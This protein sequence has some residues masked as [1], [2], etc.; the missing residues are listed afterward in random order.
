MGD[1]QN[2][3]PSKQRRM[4]NAEMLLVK[5]LQKSANRDQTREL[6]ET[7]DS[8]VPILSPIR[9]H[10]SCLV[11][12]RSVTQ[13]L[14]DLLEHV[15]RIV[16]DQKKGA[17]GISST[18]NMLYKRAF[19]DSPF[20]FLVVSK[21]NFNII[22]MSNVLEKFYVSIPFSGPVGH[23]ILHF[24]HQSEQFLLREVL[25]A[26]SD[27]KRLF[28]TM[29]HF[30]TFDDKCVH[31][32]PLLLRNVWFDDSN[33]FAFLRFVNCEDVAQVKPTCARPEH[34]N[35]D[36][37]FD[38]VSSSILPA[39]LEERIR[40]HEPTHTEG[41]LPF[42]DWHKSW[43][44]FERDE[45]V[46]LMA[47]QLSCSERSLAA[48]SACFRLSLEV[49]TK[50]FVSSCILRYRMRIPP[51]L[52]LTA[53]DL[54][55][56]FCIALDGS[57]N[58]KDETSFLCVCP[59]KHSSDDCLRYTEFHLKQVGGTLLCYH[60]RHVTLTRDCWLTEGNLCSLG[61]SFEF[62][63]VSLRVNDMH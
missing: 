30:L 22:S 57:L 29:F 8:L 54:G 53:S 7:I 50:N 16:K 14:E 32:L 62:R 35:G 42:L 39:D 44:E 2:S 25:K 34:F 55:N 6:V 60:T 38:Q 36:F 11:S 40:R 45:G 51:Y 26:S 46:K 58:E 33:Q 20:P 41:F 56:D 9:R 17:P 15:G 52:A 31:I 24:V 49:N 48:R 61:D 28:P 19:L 5:R 21:A 13:L 3:D 12:G 18:S 23:C 63:L 43:R 27:A 10:R 47:S 37:V 1:N 59:H 4:S